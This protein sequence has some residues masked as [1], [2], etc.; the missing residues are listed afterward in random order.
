[1]IFDMVAKLKET[2]NRNLVL[3]KSNVININ[4]KVS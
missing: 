2:M 1:M 4:S 3:K